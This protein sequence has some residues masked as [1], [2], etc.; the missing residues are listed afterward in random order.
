MYYEQPIIPKCFL[1][2]ESKNTF[3][4]FY[5][6]TY[7]QVH[8]CIVIG[9]CLKT[10]LQIISFLLKRGINYLTVMICSKKKLYPNLKDIM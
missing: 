1:I 10:Y 4:T 8:L 5:T 6:G 3:R 7:K 9:N 2:P